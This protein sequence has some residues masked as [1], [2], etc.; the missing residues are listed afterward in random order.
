MFLTPRIFSPH[1]LL[2]WGQNTH[3]LGDT[4][5]FVSA[6]FFWGVIFP[7]IAAFS[8]IGQKRPSE[9]PPL[10]ANPGTL[11]EKRYLILLNRPF[12]EAWVK[13]PRLIPRSHSPCFFEAS[14]LSTFYSEARFTRPFRPNLGQRLGL[15]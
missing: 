9:N 15:V 11:W 2:S 13:L 6:R 3:F 10:L 7:K 5:T 1:R 12:L 4:H 8:L 14:Q